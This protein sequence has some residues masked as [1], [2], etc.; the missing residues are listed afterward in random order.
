MNL[1]ELPARY[2]TERLLLRPFVRSDYA[3]Y[4]AY[5]SQ[6]DVYRYLL[7]APPTERELGEKFARVLD[8]KFETDSD[9]YRLAVIAQNGHFVLGEV[10]IELVN[11]SAGQGEI[12]Y[13]FNPEYGRQGFATEAVKEILRIGFEIL[14]FH[15]LFARLDATNGGSVRLL[16]RLGL[17]REAHLVQNHRFN[18]TW[19]DECIYALLRAEWNAQSL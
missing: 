15:R 1:T 14:H 9:V 10:M 12:G 4:V 8:A 7:S 19:I 5:H 16:E 2:E 3:D 6:P 13:I 17:R 11:Q 18:E